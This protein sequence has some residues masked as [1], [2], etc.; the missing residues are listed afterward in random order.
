MKRTSRNE[1]AVKFISPTFQSIHPIHADQ[2]EE[3]VLL[4]DV[5]FMSS[6]SEAILNVPSYAS[7]LEA[8]DHSEAYDYEKKLLLLLQW[9]RRGKFWVLKSPHHL[10]YLDVCSKVFPDSR[11]VWMHRNVES[12]VPSFLSMIYYSRS[13]F[14]NEVDKR[15]LKFHWL[16]KLALMLNGGLSYRASNPGQIMDVNFE[17]FVKDENKVVSSILSHLIDE[18]LK[19]KEASE[20]KEKYMS[21]HRYHLE[22]RNIKLSDLNKQFEGYNMVV[23][24]LSQA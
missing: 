21:K 23:K 14:T 9:Q 18:N 11:I 16:N 20:N 8:Q 5:H 17:D 22:D 15:A 4:L 6:S 19:V 2:P 10:Q 7:W 3:D 24:E 13:M 12:C 1:R